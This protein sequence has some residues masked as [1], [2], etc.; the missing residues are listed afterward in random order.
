M[1]GPELRVHQLVPLQQLFVFETL[2]AFVADKLLFRVLGLLMV[3][4]GRGMV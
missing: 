2:A 1:I 3:R 4:Y